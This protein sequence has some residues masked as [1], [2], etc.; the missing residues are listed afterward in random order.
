MGIFHTEATSILTP[1]NPDR[2]PAESFSN[3]DLVDVAMEDAQV[4]GQHG[5]NEDVEAYPQDDHQCA[6]TKKTAA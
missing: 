3:P 5:E 6:S 4:E 1:T 2:S